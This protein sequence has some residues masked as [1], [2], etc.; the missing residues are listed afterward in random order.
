MSAVATSRLP[1]AVLTELTDALGPGGALT[2]AADVAPYVVDFRGLYHG[3]TPL[4]AR[5]DSVARV[6][7]V[8][9]IAAR[10]GLAIVPQGGNT[11]YCGG[12][13][14]HESG[15]EIVLSLAR[16][17]RVRAVDAAGYSITVD[18]GCTLARV[19]QAAAES[20]RLFP[21]SLGSEG[22]CQ[23]GG[24]L[25]TNAGGTAVLRYGMVRDLVLGLEVVLPD[26]RRLDQLKCLRKDNTG[27]DVKQLFL[28]A[29]GTLGV[30]T[31]ACLKL[32]PLPAAQLTAFV[33]VDGMAAAVA[34]LSR[35]RARF[36][37][38]VTAFEYLPYA[39]YELAQRRLPGVAHPIADA[40]PG[41]VLLELGLSQAAEAQ[42]D[43]LEQ[44]LSESLARAELRDAVLA[45]SARERDALWHLR[46]HIPE[47]QK[48][49]GASLKHDIS[50]PITALAAF[51]AEAE[52]ALARLAPAGRL[53]AY[54]HVGDGNLHFNLSPA[55]G[56]S[57]AELTALAEPV[58]RLVHDLVAA[59]GGSFSAEHGIGQLKVAELVHYKDPV[60]LDLMRSVKQ[61]LDPQGIMNPGKVLGP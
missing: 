34:L 18:A 31:G 48:R 23:I 25:S 13:T 46:T 4:V 61:A 40:Y 29:E 16:L 26:G 44:F 58:Q 47:A 38:A 41:Y 33:A 1:A 20:D 37:D 5:P 12:A 3:R 52:S 10:R 36:G 11:S 49:E 57:D 54:G 7:A 22:T 55:A 43:A 9:T 17:N 14:P 15:A 59:H 2:E 19:Q 39:A 42:S 30:I 8:V 32:F 45:R 53:I 50:L 51:V 28:G 24:N 21:L 27:Y 6:Q 56:A 35:L 60:A